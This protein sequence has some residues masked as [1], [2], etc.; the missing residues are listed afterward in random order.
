M[1][2]TIKVWQIIFSLVKIGVNNAELVPEVGSQAGPLSVLVTEDKLVAVCTKDRCFAFKFGV[3]IRPF[4]SISI[5][6][7]EN[8]RALLANDVWLILYLQ[9]V[10]K[11]VHFCNTES[12]ID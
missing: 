10:T 3:Y 6:T 9:L 11:L 2:A 5:R 1:Q 4:L 7:V 8:R 12:L